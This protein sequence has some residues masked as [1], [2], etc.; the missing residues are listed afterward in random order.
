MDLII[1][2]S[3]LNGAIL[4]PSS[5]SHTIR[6]LVIAT[7]AQ[8]M[9]KIYRPLVSADTLSCLHG[10]KALGGKYEEAEDYWQIEG[11]AGVQLCLKILLMWAI[12]GR[13]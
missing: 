12:P 5:K 2:A 4:I 9:S 1:K 13:H 11:V 8:G 7:L 10:C 3:T 6:A